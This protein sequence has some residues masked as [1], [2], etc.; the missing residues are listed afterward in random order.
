MSKVSDIF[1]ISEDN[2]LVCGWS[3]FHGYKYPIIV[4]PPKYP[5]GWDAIRS[6]VDHL[7]YPQV[8]VSFPTQVDNANEEKPW[9]TW[10]FYNWEHLFTDNAMKFTGD[11]EIVDIND[12]PKIRGI[13]YDE[14]DKL[15]KFF[16]EEAKYGDYNGIF[17]PYQIES[18]LYVVA[19]D[20]NGKII[21]TAGSHYETPLTVQLGNIYVKKEYRGQG[22]GRALSTAVTLSIIRSRRTPTL[23]VN[24]ENNV[25]QS[26]YEKMGFEVF[27]QFEFYQGT[28]R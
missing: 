14:K 22:I 10:D 4:F 7:N 16:E 13:G 18:D 3:I 6:F 1:R 19:E 25:A 28:S 23:F 21:A 26:L 9:T 12:L 11:L 5:Q 2:K 15:I 8:M 27:N 20:D 17:H 24:T